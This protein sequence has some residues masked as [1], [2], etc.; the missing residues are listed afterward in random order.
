MNPQDFEP[1]ELLLV[2]DSMD[3][4]NMAIRELRKHNLANHLLHVKNGEEAL[5]YLFGNGEFEGRNINDIP[6]VVLLD[7]KM[8][9]IGG[10]EVLQKIRADERTKKIPVVVLT[11]SQEEKD[12]T[13]AYNLGVNSYIVKP[14]DFENFSNSIKEIGLYWLVLNKTS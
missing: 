11:S 7:L 9:K 3:D 1:I 6:K 14:I 12:I 13:E 10:I 2:E 5:E 8:P 4:A